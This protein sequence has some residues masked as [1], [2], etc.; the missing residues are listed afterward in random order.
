MRERRMVEARKLSSLAN[1]KC[2]YPMIEFRPVVHI[3]GWIAVLT[4][5][6]L[7]LPT[8]TDISVGDPDW[9]PFS[10]SATTA[11]TL[12]LMMTLSTF[13]ERTL[14]L[15]LRQ[16]FLVT[17]LGWVVVGVLGA[18]PMTGIGIGFLDALF[19][20]ISGITTTGSTVI[21]GLDRMP[22]GLLLWR[23]IL[24]WIGGIGIIAIAVLILPI[25]RI[26]GMQLFRI[27]SSDTS[28]EKVASALSMLTGL[29]AVYGVLT[30]A[31]AGSFY[32]CGMS[33][34]DAL[35]HAMATVS[36]GG[37]STHDASFRYFEGRSL[38]WVGTVFMISGAT[39]FV[40]YI[41]AIRGGLDSLVRDSQVRVFIGLLVALS[42]LVS[43]WL[44]EIR[45]R[46]FLD[47][48]TVAAFNITSIVTTTGF[49]SENY[50]I[51]GAGAAGLFLVL[52]FVG[53]CTGSTSGAIKI[54]R[55]QILFL[56][57]RAQVKR[58]ISPNRVVP[59]SYNGKHLTDDVSVSVLAFWAVFIA[60]I[61]VVTVVLNVLGLDIV[62]AYSASVTAISN[63]GPGLGDIVGPTGN[64]ATLPDAAKALLIGAMLA[65]RLEILALLVTLNRE[66]WRY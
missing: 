30:A 23:A 42:L 10:I 8:L 63:V 15:D 21:V 43:L 56:F 39:P 55:F 62:T 17:V 51:W 16:A 44:S 32:A 4:G 58:L 53:G 12:G 48:V 20:S 2:A 22:P 60:S 50:N 31:C 38:Q 61:A 57:V 14:V 3:L 35:T 29:L 25:L 27:E 54:Y 40:L 47:A 33:G 19:E 46:P 1:W 41:R 5:M 7:I 65:G 36:T 26:G 28:S 24:Q 49:V 64:F 6:L 18:I 13:G 45:D 52:M 37:F 9:L 11:L 66:F 59:L 34:F